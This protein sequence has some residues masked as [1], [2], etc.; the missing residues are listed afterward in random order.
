MPLV[1]DFHGLA[2]GADIATVMS[3]FGE[4]GVQEGFATVFPNGTG[5]PVRWEAQTGDAD[6][7][8]IEFVE[9]LP[10]LGHRRALHRR[11]PRVRRRPVDGCLHELARRL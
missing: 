9:H 8:D 3:K 2:E 11:I 6:N 5:Q 4:L 7:P 1:V 10:R